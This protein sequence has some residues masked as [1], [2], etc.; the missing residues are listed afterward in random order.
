M[1]GRED[2]VGGTVR[3]DVRVR[4]ARVS[5]ATSVQ[6]TNKPS[7]IDRMLALSMFSINGAVRSGHANRLPKRHA[8]VRQ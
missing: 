3:M 7:L 5:P 2:E 8:G 6:P 1:L 4:R